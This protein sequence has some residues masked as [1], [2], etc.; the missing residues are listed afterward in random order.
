MFKPINMIS[1]AVRAKARRTTCSVK[2]LGAILLALLMTLS[3]PLAAQDFQKGLA[4]FEVQKLKGR[5]T[6]AQTY[7]NY[8]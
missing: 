6:N 4:A 7:S 8:T 2:P 5:W 3:S 1:N